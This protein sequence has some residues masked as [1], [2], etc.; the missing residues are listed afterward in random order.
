MQFLLVCG[1]TD[2]YSKIHITMAAIGLPLIIYFIY[3]FSYVGAA[4]AT[5]IIEAGV[6]TMTFFSVKNLTFSHLHDT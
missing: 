4:M 5:A 3:C 6:F 2:V 1:K